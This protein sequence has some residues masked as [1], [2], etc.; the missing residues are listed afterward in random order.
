MAARAPLDDGRAVVTRRRGA[1]CHGRLKRR[2]GVRGRGPPL[3]PESALQERPE[4]LSAADRRCVSPLELVKTLANGVLCKPA[5]Q[6]YEA[7]RAPR[8]GGGGA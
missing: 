1:P 7:A 8:Q 3:D 5:R 4:A 2:V 6:T